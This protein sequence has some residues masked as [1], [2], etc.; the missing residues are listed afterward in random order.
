[1]KYSLLL[2]GPVGH[3]AHPYE[4]LTLSFAQLKELFKVIVDGFP[5]LEVTEKLD[6][7]NIIITFDHD[8]GKSLVIRRMG[9]HAAMGGID[10]EA[11]RNFFTKDKVEKAKRIALNKGASEEEAEK[12]SKGAGIPHVASA[13]YDAMDEFEK[14]ARDMPREFFRTEDGCVIFY[15]G[16]VI[17][18]R[19]RNIVDYDTQ[20]L[21]LHRTKHSKLCPGEKK[22]SSMP[23]EESQQYSAFLEKHL[24]MFSAQDEE[25]IPKVKV[26]ALRN[27][28]NI[29]VDEE[30]LSRANQNLDNLMATSNLSGDSTIRD[31]LKRVLDETI[32]NKLE[33][34]NGPIADRISEAVLFYVTQKKMPRLRTEI[35]PI[36]ELISNEQTRN[37]VK[38]FL[39]SNAALSEIVR[40]AI[41]PIEYIVHNFAADYL[42]GIESLYILN[43]E[44]VVDNLRSK[45]GSQ[46]TRVQS[47]NGDKDL[48]VLRRNIRKMVSHT[49]DISAAEALY[50]QN[51]MKI[52]DKIDTAVEGLVFSYNGQEYK[53]TGQFAPINQ[54]MGLGRFARAPGKR[55][56][57]QLPSPMTYEN[58]LREEIED[59]TSDKI[60]IFSGGFKPPHVGHYLAS[61]YLAEQ[62]QANKLYIL[63]GSN[64]R[65]SKDGSISVGPD[66]SEYFWSKYYQNAPNTNF[67]VVII[68]ISGSPVKWV[69]EKMES[70]DF[71]SDE[72]YCGIGAAQ[73]DPDGASPEDSR[74][75]SMVNKYDNANQIIIPLQGGSIR[76][77][78]MRELLASDD[79]RFFLFLP[80]HLNS[81]EKI[82]LR[83]RL[84]KKDYLK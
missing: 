65:T 24:Q 50:D 64:I 45:V 19:S 49:G 83:S 27:F 55:D 61:R 80:D 54:I 59:Q 6:G 62:S 77:S 35:A 4:N 17:D 20:D 43:H 36:L 67:E 52:Y 29:I 15:N 53:I 84:S 30:I 72:I 69:Y 68:K 63:V 1:M 75:Q 71:S 16:E 78:I 22:L 51:I 70:G 48:N 14:V 34:V 38:D 7:Q 73:G 81:E 11:V 57:D 76:G 28:E 18:P 47:L 9:E 56:L 44:E 23:D 66:E 5:D 60:A 26:N 3:M 74:W 25:N 82:E 13:F 8:T 42:K 10:K 21:V 33:G 79:D 2:E 31:Y 32:E 37:I 12:Q 41:R 58:L 39:R 46:V 40:E